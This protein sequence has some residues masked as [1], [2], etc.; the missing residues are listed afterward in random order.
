MAVCL[1]GLRAGVWNSCRGSELPDEQTGPIRLPSRSTN[2][3]LVRHSDSSVGLYT[4]TRYSLRALSQEEWAAGPLSSLQILQV[5]GLLPATSP[6]KGSKFLQKT[7]QL[8]LLA[9]QWL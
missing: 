5:S 3:T 8:D 6:P 4:S 7:M 9:L 1:C 2:C